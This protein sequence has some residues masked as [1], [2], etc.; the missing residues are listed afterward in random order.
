MSTH[1]EWR[2]VDQLA[3]APQSVPRQWLE[4]GNTEPEL[5]GHHTTY[6]ILFR[7]GEEFD[8]E[9]HGGR[10]WNGPARERPAIA[11]LYTT[12]DGSGAHERVY[13]AVGGGDRGIAPRNDFAAQATTADHALS[14]P[15]E[16]LQDLYARL[17]DAYQTSGSD[18]DHALDAWRDEQ[19]R[20]RR[21][22]QVVRKQ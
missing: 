18:V 7:A 4:H 15:A 16:H 21:D 14:T 11:V 13:P 2:F 1:R 17:I 12:S 10:V 9:M 5:D 19:Q 6:P 3:R 20:D 22:S 8:V